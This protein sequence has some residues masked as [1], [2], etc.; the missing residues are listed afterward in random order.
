MRTKIHWKNSIPSIHDHINPIRFP[1]SKVIED[2]LIGD[3]YV[4]A[5]CYRFDR[6]H[7]AVASYN[8]IHIILV[9]YKRTFIITYNAFP[10]INFCHSYQPF[11]V[12]AL[13][14]N[15]R[16]LPGKFFKP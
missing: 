13:L 15:F 3:D 7:A 8:H 6:S 9:S 1:L 14:F 4:T 2:E 11:C 16:Q 12:F 5:V 10:D